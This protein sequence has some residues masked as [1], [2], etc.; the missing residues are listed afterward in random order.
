M[1]CGAGFS[2]VR[3]GVRAAESAGSGRLN[4]VRRCVTVRA[5]DNDNR[6]LDTMAV[7]E[8]LASIA[9]AR[10]TVLPKGQARLV[11]DGQEP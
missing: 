4:P 6:F 3:V 5:F 1:V 8:K 10:A 7:D 2:G 9:I 11:G